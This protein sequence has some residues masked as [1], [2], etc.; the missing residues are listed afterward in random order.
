MCARFLAR[1][2]SCCPTTASRSSCTAVSGTA[3]RAVFTARNATRRGGAK[4]YAAIDSAISARLA[5]CATSAIEWCNCGST[6]HPNESRCVLRPRHGALRRRGVSRRS[7]EQARGA[8]DS[9]LVASAPP[10]DN[11]G[12]GVPGCPPAGSAAYDDSSRAAQSASQL[13]MIPPSLRVITMVQSRGL[14][15]AAPVNG[16]G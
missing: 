3:V 8:A 9:E 14:G 2:I 7:D 10:E 6:T 5:N 15:P 4:R 16:A 11:T 13:P 12:E 1:P